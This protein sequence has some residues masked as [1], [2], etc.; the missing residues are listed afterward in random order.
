MCIATIR[1]G[2]EF[3]MIQELFHHKGVTTTMIYSEVLNRGSLRRAEP[4]GPVLT[5]GVCLMH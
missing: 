5:A 1:V 2:Y 3:R 4:A